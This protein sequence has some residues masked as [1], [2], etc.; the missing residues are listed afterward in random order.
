MSWLCLCSPAYAF[1]R[2]SSFSETQR[3]FIMMCCTLVPFTWLASCLWLLSVKFKALSR[4]SQSLGCT[5]CSFASTFSILSL[6]LYLAPRVSLLLSLSPSMTKMEILKSRSSIWTT[7]SSM[8]SSFWSQTLSN[9]TWT[10]SCSTWFLALQ[11]KKRIV[12]SKLST[13]SCWERMCRKWSSSEISRYRTNIW[14]GT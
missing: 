1:A 7:N 8:I 13:I 3:M 6:T 10:P 5:R 4:Q 14:R 12:L 9:C 11:K 2:F